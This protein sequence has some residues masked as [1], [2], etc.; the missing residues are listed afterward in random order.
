METG[1]LRGNVCPFGTE[2]IRDND[3]VRLPG[4]LKCHLII[5]CILYEAGYLVSFGFKAQIS[6]F[7]FICQEWG[8]GWH[9]GDGQTAEAYRGDHTL[10]SGGLRGQCV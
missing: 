5:L 2:T 9:G 10:L 8:M 4:K 1:L 6:E 3:Y 7:A